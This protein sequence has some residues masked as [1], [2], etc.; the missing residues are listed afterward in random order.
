MLKAAFIAA[1]ACLASTAGARLL[2]DKDVPNMAG[3]RVMDD[4]TL[5]VRTGATD[6]DA[7]AMYFWVR[8]PST[9]S[10]GFAARAQP[11]SMLATRDFA[12]VA[13]SQLVYAKRQL[14][15]EAT[16]FLLPVA[17][18]QIRGEVVGTDASKA[19]LS[20]LP[21][22]DGNRLRLSGPDTSSVCSTTERR[23]YCVLVKGA[24]AE[25]NNLR[26]VAQSVFSR[27]PM[28]L[29]DGLSQASMSLRENGVLA[30]EIEIPATEKPYAAAGARVVN[31][32]YLRTVLLAN[33]Q[34]VAAS[35]SA[36]VAP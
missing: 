13:P 11:I 29:V 27:L 34:P 20:F 28:Q 15:R 24:G 18:F 6:A 35:A 22:V 32:R 4:L 23:Q 30:Y 17:T 21:A 8:G 36:S 14:A 25:V 33:G 16:R 31:A 12:T 9:Q 26:T 10:R 5:A 2:A 1:L 19:A 7:V 3:V